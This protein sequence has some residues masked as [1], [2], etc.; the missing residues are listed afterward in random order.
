MS[1]LQ[2]KV[3]EFESHK[4]RAK[5]I[6]NEPHFV[7]KDV[8]D[9]LG[10]S[11]SDNAI[12]RHVD[13]EDKLT[14]RISASGQTRNMTVVNESGLYA[15]IFGS[16]LDKAKE[17]K[18]WVTSE[19][20]PSIRK[21]GIY[22][23]ENTVEQML[24]DPDTAIQLLETIKQERAEKALLEQQIAE[25]EPKISY[26]D[27]ILSSKDTVTITQ[28][29]ADYGMSAQ[30]M[31]KLLNELNVQH[32]V[33]GQWILYRKHMQQGY[34]K[35]HTTDI[36]KTDGSTMVVMNTK[37]TQKGRLFLYELL[38]SEEYYPQMELELIEF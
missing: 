18:R 22:A 36:Q 35:S 21:H 1:E 5:V 14:H 10:Y 12:R 37:W 16:K 7:G 31:N 28:I 23:T 32:K 30:A 13:E 4:V 3:F 8:A 17:F 20:L 24:N 33:G 26:L 29:A 2:E 15:L 19:V 9:I 27:T 25:Y 34:T 38:K 6:N 11:R